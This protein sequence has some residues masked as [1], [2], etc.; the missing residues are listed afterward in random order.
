[1]R[2][3]LAKSVHQMHLIP[4][5]YFFVSL[6]KTNVLRKNDKDR[7]THTNRSMAH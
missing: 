7:Y 1:M 3:T 6:K 4:K 5:I 2:F